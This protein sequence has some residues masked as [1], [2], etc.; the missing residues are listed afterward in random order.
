MR[1][2]YAV[3]VFL[4]AFAAMGGSIT[5]L[6]PPSILT[7]SG[8]YFMTFNGTDLKGLVKYDG[9]AGTFELE[10]NAEFPGSVVA[11]VPMEIVNTPGAY[12]VS[13]GDS[14]RLSFNVT[15][16]GRPLLTLHLP[17]VLVALAKTR[18]GNVIDYE[19]NATGGEGEIVTKC[20]PK[21]GSTFPYGE[22]T[23]RCSAY[24][25]AGSQVDG[26]ISVKV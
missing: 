6:D 18:L 23:I 12:T 2:A 13:V 5:S 1:T 24:D 11:W 8:E 20:D 4:F 10:T 14:N 19:I 7:R 3:G 25:Q 16:P 17:E 9:P 22:S 21:P 15:K 26:I